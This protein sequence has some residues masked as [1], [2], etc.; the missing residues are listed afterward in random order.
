MRSSASNSSLSGISSLHCHVSPGTAVRITGTVSN[1]ILSEEKTQINTGAAGLA[2]KRAA[3]DIAL[4][5]GCQFQ[6]I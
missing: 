3:F 1:T 2:D 4:R 5:Y 6:R